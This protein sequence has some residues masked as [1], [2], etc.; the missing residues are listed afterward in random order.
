MKQ[1]EYIELP[2]SKPKRREFAILIASKD[3]IEK[4]QQQRKS[5]KKKKSRG[6]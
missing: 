6:F 2:K 4:F 3:E 1:Y 5:T